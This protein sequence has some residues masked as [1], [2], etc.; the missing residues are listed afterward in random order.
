MINLCDTGPGFFYFP[1]D[2]SECCFCR[3]LPHESSEAPSCMMFLFFVLIFIAMILIFIGIIACII[4]GSIAIPKLV[5]KHMHLLR[6]RSMAHEY[7]VADLMMGRDD[8]WQ[9]E[10]THSHILDDTNTSRTPHQPRITSVNTDETY[11]DYGSSTAA[12]PPTRV[13]EMSKRYHST[14]TDDASLSSSILSKSHGPHSDMESG[15]GGEGKE[16]PEPLKW[17]EAGQGVPRDAGDLVYSTD[18]E[19]G[20]SAST[21]SEMI[22]VQSQSLRSRQTSSHSSASAARIDWE[23]M[24]RLER[25]GWT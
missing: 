24:R 21:S 15:F 25:L 12:P 1:L 18:P 17:D 13:Y 5:G 3:C 9:S 11:S 8:L 7:Q 6:K 4:L 20:F 16:S 10:D 23:R 14:A 22:G 2:D 19:G